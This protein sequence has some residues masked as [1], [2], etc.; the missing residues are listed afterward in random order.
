MNLCD[1]KMK[2]VRNRIFELAAMPPPGWDTRVTA[3]YNGK[4]I[5][6]IALEPGETY[7]ETVKIGLS[8]S[9]REALEPGE[10]TLIFEVSSGSVRDS[11]ELTAVVTVVSHLIQ[12]LFS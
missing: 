9:S 5:G 4:E 2:I 10:Y 3:G 11:I 1:R 7:P 6:S 12:Q 8:P